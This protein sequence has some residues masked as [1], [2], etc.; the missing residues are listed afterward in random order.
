[1]EKTGLALKDF[2]KIVVCGIMPCYQTTVTQKLGFKPVQIQDSLFEQVGNTGTASA[3]MM[4]VAALEEAQPTSGKP[5]PKY[6]RGGRKM[7][8]GIKN[9]P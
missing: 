7:A 3:P 9:L 5:H 4:L 2:A 1:M 6:C 8:T